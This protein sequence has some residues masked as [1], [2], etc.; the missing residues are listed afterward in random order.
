M[1]K[2][3]FLIFENYYDIAEVRAHLR[4]LH[5]MTLAHCLIA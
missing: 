1:E 3:L 4:E 5:G 2:K